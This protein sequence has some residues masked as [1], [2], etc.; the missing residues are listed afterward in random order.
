MA[1]DETPAA[2]P[3]KIH[4]VRIGLN[5]V[6]QVALLLFLAVMANYLGFEHYRRWDLSRDKKFALSD[7]T[8]RFL[9]SMPG[10]ARITVLFTPS[11]PIAT[12]VQGVLT[13]YQYAAKGKL[14]VET[15]DP[16]R[17]LSRAKA[18]LDKYKIPASF[19]IP[20]VSAVIHDVFATLLIG[21]RTPDPRLRRPQQNGQGVRDGRGRPGESHDRGTAEDHRVQR[22]ASGDERL[23]GVGRREEELDRLCARPQRAAALRTSAANAGDAHRTAA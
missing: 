22:R 5:V 8:K 1:T 12:D 10:K 20:A 15:V 18:L 7:K 13:E 16:E 19:F 21:R 3:Q 14:D 9:Q 11:N 4:R 2:K 17:N 23:D 6:V